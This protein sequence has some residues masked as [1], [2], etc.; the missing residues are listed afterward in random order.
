MTV[1]IIVQ[2]Y[3]TGNTGEWILTRN[4]GLKTIKT[5][6]LSKLKKQ[7]KNICTKPG[8]IPDTYRMK[9][10]ENELNK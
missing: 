8:T 2:V 1:L 9:M 7:G 10:N 6:S 4:H 5:K 3:N